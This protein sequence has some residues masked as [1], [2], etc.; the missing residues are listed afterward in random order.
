VWGIRHVSSERTT[1]LKLLGLLSL[2]VTTVQMSSAALDSTT[3][4]VGKGQFVPL[5]TFLKVFKMGLK[6]ANVFN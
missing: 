3:I 5:Q 1:I 6:Y 2:L 4:L